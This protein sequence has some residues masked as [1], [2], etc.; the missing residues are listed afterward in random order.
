MRKIVGQ[1]SADDVL[2]C[3]CLVLLLAGLYVLAAAMQ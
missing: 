3:V 2:G 1:V